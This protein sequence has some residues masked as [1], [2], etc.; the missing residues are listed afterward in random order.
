MKL[1]WSKRKRGVDVE[2]EKEKLLED[3]VDAKLSG[4]DENQDLDK[5]I[6]A[7]QNSTRTTIPSLIPLHDKLRMKSKHYHKYSAKPYSS[8]VNW[9]ILLVTILATAYITFDYFGPSNENAVASANCSSNVTSGNWEDAGTWLCGGDARVPLS[10]ETVAINSGHTVT[11]NSDI[12]IS[13][14]SIL[15]T[16]NIPSSNTLT[17]TGT[18]GILFNNGGTFNKGTSTVKFETDSELSDVGGLNRLTSGNINFHNLT[19][20]PTITAA[21]N[22]LFGTGTITIGGDFNITSHKTPSPAVNFIVKMGGNITVTGTTNI[23]IFATQNKATP[24]LDTNSNQNYT[25]TSGGLGY[26]YINGWSGKIYGNSSTIYNTGATRGPFTITGSGTLELNGTGTHDIVSGINVYNLTINSGTYNFS[27]NMTGF[28]INGNLTV[29]GSGRLTSSMTSYTVAIIRGNITGSGTIDFSND[30]SSPSWGI[31]WLVDGNRT[32]GSSNSQAWDLGSFSVCSTTGMPTI[33]TSGNSIFTF[34]YLKIG[35]CYFVPEPYTGNGPV[36]LALQANGT[37]TWTFRGVNMENTNNF[38]ISPTSTY[39]LQ[40]STIKYSLGCMS[41]TRLAIIN[42]YNVTIENPT[43]DVG[44]RYGFA[45]G[46]GDSTISPL[47]IANNLTILNA[48]QG[49][50]YL[51]ANDINHGYYVSSY[52]IGNLIIGSNTELIVGTL[53][54]GSDIPITITGNYTNNGVF[55]NSNGT[56]TFAGATNSVITGDTTFYNLI[57]DATTDG[58][59]TVNF[60]SGS[61][62]TITNALTLNGGIGK[63]LTLGRSGGSGLD[64]YT[65]NIPANM[66]S[67]DYITVSNNNV[68]HEITPGDNVTN[69][70]NNTNWIFPIVD[71]ITPTDTSTSTPTPTPTTTTD[72]SS[73]LSV[74]SPKI[75]LVTLPGTPVE[76]EITPPEPETGEPVV[77]EIIGDVSIKNVFG[78]TIEDININESEKEAL[79]TS[80]NKNVVVWKAPWWRVGLFKAEVKVVSDGKDVK[81]TVNFIVIPLWIWIFLALTLAFEMYRAIAIIMSKKHSSSNDEFAREDNTNV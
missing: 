73:V 37:D 67:G 14:L 33:T 79:V 6:I 35:A 41:T 56:V 40:H 64:Q 30:K 61:I 29:N 57:L 45:R 48:G 21:R 11:L 52:V 25:L 55:T 34:R 1:P 19:I 69:G 15:G 49:R 81:N 60:G 78:K 68:D 43:P 23:T 28:T 8:R 58:A 72:S 32:L 27:G 66:T 26:D 70:G 54:N 62:Q 38:Y 76:I 24:I 10:S 7:V 59:K 44:C 5:K 4:K 31:S 75:G 18:T 47:N 12:S 74:S 77:T 50:T 36:D 22:Q 13:T 2:K 71:N 39:N 80:N 53:Q 20:D 51:T 63:I 46:S 42:Y 65:F 9:F 16:F 17:L 3:I